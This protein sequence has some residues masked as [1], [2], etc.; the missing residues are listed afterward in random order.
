MIVNIFLLLLL[1]GFTF[2]CFFR[3]EAQK[4]ASVFLLIAVSALLVWFL[5]N[6]HEEQN[7]AFLIPWLQY[8]DLS[9]IINLSSEMQNYQ[10][11]YPLF[12]VSVITM[13]IGTFNEDETSKLKLNGTIALSLSSLFLLCCSSNL[14]QL[15]IGS[16]F[17]SICGGYLIN[18]QEAR[19][20]YAYYNLLAEVGLFS[21]FAVI[22]GYLGNLNISSLK[23][24]Q[25]VGAHKDWVAIVLLLSVFIKT[26]MFPFHNQLLGLS[27]INFN[28]Q[29]LIIWAST[30]ISGIIILYKT[31]PLLS[32]SQYSVPLLQ[33]IAGLTL[34][35]ALGGALII[36]NIKERAVYFALMIYA[37]IY[38]LIP[39]DNAIGITNISTYILWGYLLT[40]LFYLVFKA[41]SNEIYISKMGSFF[42]SMKFSFL[43]SCVIFCGF[44]SEL[45]LTM[46]AEEQKWALALSVI[47]TLSGAH[48]F[49][50]VYM[51]TPH[52]DERV[53]A[54]LKNPAW[55]IM[56]P[57]LILM[58]VLLMNDEIWQ[59][60]TIYIYGV[61]LCL[62]F[63]DIFR[64]MSS[65]ADNDTI[66]EEDY[67]EKIY[68]LLILTPIRIL[69]RVLWLLVDFILI[70]RTI[71]NSLKDSTSFMVKISSYIH[72][73]TILSGV[74]LSIGGLAAMIIYF[75]IRG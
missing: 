73:S 56:L 41:S 57:T 65:L 43:I 45:L 34:L 11:I 27:N 12:V 49:H 6:W 32:I 16:S 21:V 22:Y 61:V 19:N 63:I 51:G 55:Y 46:G 44:I 74:V 35:W 8:K 29:N 71:I 50:Q 40:M 24:F 39:L 59:R 36:D 3:L 9:V 20:K 14:I 18:D 42:R 66:Q 7:V 31:I 72:T 48:F 69:G 26:G 5:N 70:E 25:A 75:Y 37:Y 30:P 1:I 2:P 52:A 47:I 38:A 53:A 62:I 68:E 60:Q 64:K 17:V 15:I 13:L 54:L 28:R 23:N 4:G 10:L 33:I 58:S 67:F